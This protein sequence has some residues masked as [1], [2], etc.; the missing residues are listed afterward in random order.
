[1]N[2]IDFLAMIIAAL[3]GIIALVILWFDLHI[4]RKGEAE[5]RV[6][7]REKFNKEEEQR[8]AWKRWLE[9]ERAELVKMGDSL[10]RIIAS[11]LSKN[12][13]WASD[14]L[15]RAKLG[16]YIETIF[17]DRKS[18]F[19]LEPNPKLFERFQ[20]VVILFGC[21]TERRSRCPGLKPLV[22][23]MSGVGGVTQAT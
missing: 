6:F 16:P 17:G 5:D 8:D 3:L 14:A 12:N 21:E 9:Q 4:R 10:S 1:M 23:S 11:E 15:E 18:H 20:W 19:R 13:R 22:A 7:Q 2:I